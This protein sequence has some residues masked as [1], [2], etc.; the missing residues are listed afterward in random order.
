MQ[1][2]PEVVVTLSQSEA[3]TV[4]AIITQAGVSG[5]DAKIAQ[6]QAQAKFETALTRPEETNGS[7]QL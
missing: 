3:R 7:S 2:E 1:V 5:A 6:G 4:L